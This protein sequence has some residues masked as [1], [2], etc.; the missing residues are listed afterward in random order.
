[1]QLKLPKLFAKVYVNKTVCLI[2]SMLFNAVG[3]KKI[4]S[5]LIPSV[6]KKKSYNPQSWHDT[7]IEILQPLVN[8]NQPNA[9]EKNIPY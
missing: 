9:R 6:Q 7:P 3:L 8:P 1:M 5:Q 2:V 4:R